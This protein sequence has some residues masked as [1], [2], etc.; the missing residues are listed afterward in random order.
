M[1]ASKQT[2]VVDNKGEEKREEVLKD[3]ERIKEKIQ[4][5]TLTKEELVEELAL[6]K[7]E[8]LEKEKQCW[9]DAKPCPYY[10][11]INGLQ[12]A[13]KYCC[14]CHRVDIEHLDC[15]LSEVF[16]DCDFSFVGVGEA[17]EAAKA[18]A[19]QEIHEEILSVLK[20]F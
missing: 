20:L 7:K 10:S 11:Q 3:L 8:K 16:T 15:V 1:E 19:W 17:E 12:D 13:R 6:A 4:E 18:E 2:E 14:S 5:L 9:W